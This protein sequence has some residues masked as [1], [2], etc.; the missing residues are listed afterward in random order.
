M[1]NSTI[2]LLEESEESFVSD[3]IESTEYPFLFSVVVPIYNAEEYLAETLESVVKQSIGFKKSIQL[4]LVNNASEDNC[5]EICLMYKNEYPDNVSIIN[6]DRNVSLSGARN[7]GVEHIKGKYVNFLDSEDKWEFDAFELAN[8]YFVL[9]NDDIDIV[10]CRIKYFDAIKKWH[11][12]DYKFKKTRIVNIRDEYQCP[13]LAVS[14]VFIKS[15]VV[16]E[17]TFNEAIMHAEEMRYI[18]EIILCRCKYALLRS[19]VYYSRKRK[20]PSESLSKIGHLRK[21]WYFDTTRDS[22]QYLLDLSIKLFG[23]IIPY[24]QSVVMHELQW[25]FEKPL[26]PDLSKQ[27]LEDYLSI[28]KNLLLNIDDTIICEQKNLT[29]ER[30]VVALSMKHGR[31]IKPEIR[32]SNRSFFF[33][34]AMIFRNNETILKIATIEEK[35]NCFKIEGIVNLCLCENKYHIFIM[36]DAKQRYHAEWFPL[37]KSYTKYSFNEPIH[38]ERGFYIEIPI[39]DAHKLTFCIE[40]HGVVENLLF[41]FLPICK[42]TKRNKNSYFTAG[43]R[44]FS[45]TDNHLIIERY[46]ILRHFKK[47]C[48]LLLEIT[49]K[50]DFRLAAW[51]MLIIIARAFAGR[52]KIWLVSDRFSLA[53][54]NG[55]FFFRYLTNEIKSKTIKPY[56]VISKKSSDYERMKSIGPVLEYNSKKYRL[57]LALSDK[58]VSSQ[59]FFGSNNSFKSRTEFLQ[60]LFHFKFIYLQHGVIKDNHADSQGKFRKNFD[61]FVTSA[62]QEYESIINGTGGNYRYDESVVKLTGM[63]R[64]DEII[65]YSHLKRNKHITIAPTWRRNIRGQWD[66][67]QRCEYNNSHKESDFYKFYNRLINDPD[68]L[69]I[70][71]KR[72]YSG[73]LRL[74]SLMHEQ[75]YDYEGNDLITVDI[76]KSSLIDEIMQ[77]ALLVTDYSSISFDYI[78][79]GIPVIYTQFDSDTFYSSHSYYRGY[80]DYEQD[81]FGPIS[82]DYE[83]TIKEIIKAIEND[84]IMEDSYK[85]RAD[86]FFAFHDTNN[87]LR[88]YHEILNLDRE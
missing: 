38:A 69:S 58:V 22:H 13:Q 24:I 16:R 32:L 42:L 59:S 79:V 77:T 51:R 45:Y 71:R 17:K 87:C 36:D 28:I 6:L 86:E 5:G 83:S 80:F 81:G 62:K 10:S 84:C 18:N 88:I 64:H 66:E 52:K 1:V 23:Y 67:T 12:L 47:E 61:L 85:K 15:E 7:R 39:A 72:G 82:Y 35:G 54:D 46:G 44:V 43:K 4:I 9:H 20:K 76:E 48:N 65:A 33:R 53:G 56:F 19:C 31:D 37:D 49:R 11:E 26:A 63:P 27:E 70:M 2:S 73:K 30:K 34:E 14:S 68:L 50:K 25:R 8:G 60:D 29:R 75:S 41:S 78:Y 21:T 40:Y 3:C 55:E 57:F 74:H